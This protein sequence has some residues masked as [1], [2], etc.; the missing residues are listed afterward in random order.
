MYLNYTCTNVDIAIPKNSNTTWA[1]AVLALPD[2]G[3]AAAGGWVVF[4]EEQSH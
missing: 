3:A 2:Y 4:V 1:S